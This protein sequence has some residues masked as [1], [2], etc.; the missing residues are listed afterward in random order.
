L[1]P[2]VNLGSETLAIL[3]VLAERHRLIGLG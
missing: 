3:P 1:L 2:I